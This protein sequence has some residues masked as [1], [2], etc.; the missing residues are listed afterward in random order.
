VGRGKYR[1]KE[2]VQRA[3]GKKK[4]VPEELYEA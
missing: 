3:R 1:R 4:D 2:R